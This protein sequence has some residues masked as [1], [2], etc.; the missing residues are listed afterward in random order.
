MLGNLLDRKKIRS[1]FETHFSKLI[2]FVENEMDTVKSLFDIQKNLKNETNEIVVQR[3]MPKVAGTLK[4][5]QELKDRVT[6]P[7][8]SLK[9]LDHT[10]FSAEMYR[11]ER[12]ERKYNELLVLIDEFSANVYDEWCSQVGVLSNDNLQK[13][14][15]TR[16]MHDKSISTNF[17]PQLIAVLKEVK[18]LKF[19][20]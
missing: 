11:I 3:N 9:K 6:R 13:N 5:C 1:D 10:K 16:N 18:Y 8:E 20:K 4:W 12:I 7:F 17:D 19:F 15:I 14:L 2:S